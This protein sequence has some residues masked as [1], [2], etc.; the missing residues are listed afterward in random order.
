MM[1][2]IPIGA[3]ALAL[4]VSTAEPRLY[5][6]NED[7]VYAFID[8]AG[9]RAATLPAAIAQAR[10]FS[11]GLAAVARRGASG[12]RWGFVDV[13]GAIVIAPR[14]DA[15][16]DFAEGL[17]AVVAGGRLGYVD[18]TGAVVVPPQ[19]LADAVSDAA[20]S[21]GL[22][23]V[24]NLRSQ[25]GY[26][27]R[28]GRP[29]IPFQYAF[30]APFA[31]DRARVTVAAAGGATLFGYVDRSGRW[32]VRP[33][34][35]QARDFA[36]GLA[37]VVDG[38]HAAFIDPDG[39]AAVTLEAQDRSA[40]TTGEDGLPGSF[41][42][43]LAAV[44]IGCEWGFIDRTGATVIPPAYVHAGRFVGGVAPVDIGDGRVAK[45]G[46]VDRRGQMTIAAQFST[47]AAFAGPLALVQMGGSD[48]ELLTRALLRGLE[49]DAANASIKAQAKANIHP[50]TAMRK[51]ELA[52]VD[53]TGRIVWHHAR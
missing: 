21:G 14:F 33:R 11:E 2:A 50:G 36:E 40:C 29:V 43:G 4:A 23:G 19:F 34:F 44:R 1:R 26:I 47:A 16:G 31:G 5:L 32:A 53:T 8:A 39:R 9:G 3:A 28:H 37:A 18:K 20:F 10:P 22:A 17:A 46:Y 15:V 12:E 35:A 6:V 24:A 41:S 30:A 49:D 52:Y 13:H 48:E 45:W 51:P 25:R 7:G 38:D 42:E 27:D